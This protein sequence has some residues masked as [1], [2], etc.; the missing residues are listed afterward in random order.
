MSSS[1]PPVPHA[2]SRS[3]GASLLPSIGGCDIARPLH[4][5]SPAGSRLGRVLVPG[6]L[7]IAVLLAGLPLLPVETPPFFDYPNHLA[8]VDAI[9]RLGSDPL[10]SANFRLSSFLLPNVLSDLVLL[11][12]QAVA[13]PY[14]AGRLLVFLTI[15]LTV[16]GIALLGRAAHGRWSPWAILAALFA[17]NEMVFWGFLNYNLG[18]AL[19]FFGLALWLRLAERPAWQRLLAGVAV[20]VLI[21]LAHLVA[22]GLYAVGC[23][24]L[25]LGR[26]WHHR[27]ES[28]E[29]VVRRLGLAV[30]Q[31][32]P[33]LVLH[34]AA[35]PAG[36]LPLDIR[37]DISAWGK[38]SPFFRV[39]SSGNPEADRAMLLAALG[40]AALGLLL[41]RARL[42]LGLTLAALAYAGLVLVLPYA[43]LGS[44]FLDSRIA[45]AVALT[46]IAALGP[47]RLGR[48]G[49]AIACLVLLG[50]VAWRSAVL[51]ADWREQASSIAEA[52]AAFSVLP[53]GAVLASASARPFELGDWRATRYTKPTHE[54]T[55]AYAAIDR[56]VVLPNLYAK[57]GQN[58]LVF[59]PALPELLP[60]AGNPIPRVFDEAGLRRFVGEVASVAR[61]AGVAR[62]PFAGAYAVVWHRP[63]TSW[64]ADLPVRFA[65]CGRDFALVEVP[66]DAADAI[67]QTA[68]N[69]TSR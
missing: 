35:S 22:F 14:A 29:S 28:F 4:T 20:G 6:A 68:P 21:F 31:V 65:A 51:T 11:A 16:A 18:L 10:L 43:A 2:D 62:P 23:V 53:E 69:T 37:F 5:P 19:L 13:G 60:L 24:M 41:R 61:A 12:F 47:G 15:A 39:L 55:A 63:C 67:A 32:L 38:F 50:L 40:L 54:H 26:A 9:A 8:R 56:H 3:A 30:A 45:A 64:P 58:P 44:F 49:T 7:V 59:T 57:A 52:R 1:A 33:V 17:T 66:A 36:G 25:E 46:A 27:Q 34:V 48:P 42:D